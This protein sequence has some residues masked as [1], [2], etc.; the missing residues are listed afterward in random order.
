MKKT[1][2]LLFLLVCMH[3]Q[4]QNQRK[5]PIRE[6]GQTIDPGN[7]PEAIRSNDTT[8]NGATDAV[9]KRPGKMKVGRVTL[10][11]AASREVKVMDAE[12]LEAVAKGAKLT[13]ADGDGVLDVTALTT[14]H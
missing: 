5:L 2:F 10:R 14:D 7:I 9:R 8:L 6:G 13:K 4:A 12:L 3:A 11:N 1:I